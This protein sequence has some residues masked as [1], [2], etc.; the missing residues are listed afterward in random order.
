MY[1]FA[2]HALFQHF[3]VVKFFFSGK[4]LEIKMSDGIKETMHWIYDKFL[5][6][7]VIGL[8]CHLGRIS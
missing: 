7:D 1:L 3:I 5:F 6:A 2:R 4:T 8:Y